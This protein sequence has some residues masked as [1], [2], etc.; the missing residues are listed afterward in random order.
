MA[1]RKE[2]F[3]DSYKKQ[4]MNYAQ[5]TNKQRITIDISS[6]LSERI[7]MAASQQNLSVDHYLEGVLSKVIPEQHSM[8]RTWK[9][10]SRE[11]VEKLFAFQDQLL[12]EHGGIPFESSVE[13]LHES[14][15]ERDRELGI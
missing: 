2:E 15:E 9:P 13:L 12:A 8:Q 11:G 7:Q 10:I 1:L 4:S 14:R 5:P 3:D 6:E